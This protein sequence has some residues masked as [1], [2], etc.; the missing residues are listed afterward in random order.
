MP[1]LPTVAA[2]LTL[3][4]AQAGALKVADSS[5]K[6]TSGEAN[7]LTYDAKHLRD[8]KQ[9]TVWMEGE[10]GSGLGSYVQLNLKEPGVIQALRIWNGNWYSY[11]FWTRHNRA[12]ELDIEFSDGRKQKVELKDEKLPELIP[13]DSPASVEW[14]KLTI[15]SVHKGN[16]FNDTAISEVQ[17]IGDVKPTPVPVSA[18]RTSTVYPE[19]ADGTYVGANV[20]DELKDS[21]WCEGVKDGDGKGEWLEVDFGGKRT[22]SKLSILNGNGTSFSYFK[23]VNSIGSATLTFSDGSTE[24]IEVKAMPLPQNI[25]FAPRSTSTVR[26]TVDEVNK[27]TEFNDLCISELHF[28]E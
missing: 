7:G 1:T 10:D 8:G 27:G 16:T 11:D 20:A 4:V 22:V 17:L 3:G 14:V 19:D 5:A 28:Y 23:K 2:L 12:K 21:M 26:I 25:S 9:S 15:R 6:T 18:W 24:K 13:V